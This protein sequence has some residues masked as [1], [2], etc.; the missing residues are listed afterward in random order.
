MGEIDVA[1]VDFNA[2]YSLRN[3]LGQWTPR[4]SLSYTQK[5]DTQLT[6]DA[7]VV[8]MT[9]RASTLAWSPKWRGTLALG[10][11]NGPYSASVAG[12]YVGRY[13]D[14]QEW[15]TNTRHLGN[16]WLADLSATVEIGAAMGA[17]NTLLGKSYASVAVANV[18]NSLPDWSHYSYSS[19]GYDPTQYDIIGRMVQVNVGLRW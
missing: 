15:G 13:L 19:L 18:F 2:D 4:V 7:A 9:S 5:Y 11:K 1:G 3:T 16:F 6:P 10:W 14:Y 8:D 12:R 17:G